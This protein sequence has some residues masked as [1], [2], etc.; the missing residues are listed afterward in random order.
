MTIRPF[1]H[2]VKH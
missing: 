2:V 1:F